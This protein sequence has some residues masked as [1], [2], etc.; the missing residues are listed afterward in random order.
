[1][2]NNNSRRRPEMLD[3]ATQQAQNPSGILGTRSRKSSYSNSGTE[4][5][6]QNATDFGN[7]PDNSV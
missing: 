1:M 4:L 3:F 2:N 7:N 5:V 6:A